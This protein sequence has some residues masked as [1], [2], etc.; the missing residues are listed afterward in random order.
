MAKYTNNIIIGAI[1]LPKN[2]PILIQDLFKGV[3]IFEL[4]I[5]SI[6]KIIALNSQPV[7]FGDNLLIFE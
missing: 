5:P 7:E 4:L 6:K 3:N 2:S 1:I